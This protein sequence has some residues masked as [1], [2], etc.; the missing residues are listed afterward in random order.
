MPRRVTVY[1]AKALVFAIVALVVTLIAAFVAF[2]LGQALLAST[3]AN[4]SLS[5]YWFESKIATEVPSNGVH[6]IT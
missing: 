1:A 6:K 5:D 3:H 2:F 4:T